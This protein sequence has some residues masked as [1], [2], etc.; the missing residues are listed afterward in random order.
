MRGG[1][2]GGCFGTSTPGLAGEGND[3]GVPVVNLTSETDAPGA[4]QA[5]LIAVQ[6]E[7]ILLPNLDVGAVGTAVDEDEGVGLAFDAGV[8][9][10]GAGVGDDEVAL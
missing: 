1:T 6:V 8:D 2:A 9:A 5:H 7:D 4:V 10:G 3:L